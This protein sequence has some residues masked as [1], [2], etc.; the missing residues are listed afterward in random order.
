M[1]HDVQSI[2]H[3]ALPEVTNIVLEKETPEREVAPIA[4]LALPKS[5]AEIHE[6]FTQRPVV[7]EA[8]SKVSLSGEAESKES[9]RQPTRVPNEVSKAEIEE[10]RSK[11]K[12]F[13]VLLTKASRPK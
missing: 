11:I 12:D 6:D 7:T 3:E 2:Q 1:N 13:P 5:V 8:I 9:E 4:V 10:F